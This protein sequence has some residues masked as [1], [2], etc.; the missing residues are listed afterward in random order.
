MIHAVNVAVTR[1]FDFLLVPFQF[2]D[3]RWGLFA[4]SVLM[5][6]IVLYIYKWVSAPHLI[7]RT[8]DRIKANILA[9]RLYKDLWK[10]ILL[11]FVKSLYYTLK[12]FGLN[13]GPVLIL[14]PL[15]FPLFV[16]MDIR[17]GMKPYRIG[18][19][20]V[21]KAT[22]ANGGIE[23]KEIRLLSDDHFKPLMN[24]V[25]IKPLNEVNWK[26]EARKNGV[27]Q[28][29]I[30]VQDK[31]YEKNLVIGNVPGAVSNRKMRES[32]WAH[33]LYPAEPLLPDRGD[34]E[35]ISV[36]YPENDLRVGIPMHWLV[37]N[38]IVVFGVVLAFKN[39]F[40]IEF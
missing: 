29:R 28:V 37:F 18:D 19:E 24:P 39:K 25:F 32:R 21:V 36:H 8:K 16:Q 2:I 4:L 5:A 22:F 3:P 17:Y 35:S 10:V 33:F 7:K 20:I 38:L 9:I 12:Y 30:Q 31:V 40:G 34:V 23:G 14:L 1:A 15:L 27:T 13:F 26:L 11:S 6:F